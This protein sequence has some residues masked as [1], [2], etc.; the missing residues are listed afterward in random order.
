MMNT[1]EFLGA[2][3]GFLN[4]ATEYAVLRNFEGLP[5]KNTSR[6]IDIMI[7]RKSYR[8]IKPKLLSLV[9]R[10]GWKIV[11]YLN[12]DRLVTWVCGCVDPQGGVELVQFDFFFHTSVF[13]V[14]MIGAG[15][16]LKHRKFNGVLY[17]ADRDHEFLDKYLYDRAVGTEYPEKYRSTREAAEHAPA[18]IEKLSRLFGVSTVAEAASCC[19]VL[20]AATCCTGRSASQPIWGDSCI[21]FCGTIFVRIPVFPSDSPVPTVRARRR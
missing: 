20:F 3:F 1:S 7:E 15:E 8:E 19:C 14:R 13:G 11:T 21:R 4:E 5:A 12:S 6:D 2:V 16:V 10:S 18:V 17:H 9:E